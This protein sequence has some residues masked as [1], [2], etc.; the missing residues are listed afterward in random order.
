[1]A[2]DI[3]PDLIRSAVLYTGKQPLEAVC[4]VLSDYPRLISDLRA[5]R[6]R[7]S[8]FDDE[9]RSFDDRLNSLRLACENILDL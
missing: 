4:S 6:R 8:D 7:L 3:P 2:L 1:M 5:A 9:A